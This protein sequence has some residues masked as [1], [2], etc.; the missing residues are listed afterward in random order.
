MVSAYKQSIK[1]YRQIQVETATPEKL[2]IMVYECTIK[3][4]KM[5]RL[6]MEKQLYDKSAPF[7]LKAT[8]AI[9]ELIASLDVERSPDIAGALKKLY[10]YCMDR[11][12]KA[13]QERTPEDVDEV[14]KVISTLKEAWEEAFAAGVDQSLGKT[15]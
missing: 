6:L 3:F 12:R 4:L 14:I 7:V 8:A 10:I 2:L 5:A 13:I 15:G 9:I 11:L 1:G